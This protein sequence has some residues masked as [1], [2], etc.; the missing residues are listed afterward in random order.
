MAR[1]RRRLRWRA[2]GAAVAFLL[3]AVAGVAGN[4]LT[5]RLVP[6]LVAFVVL[7]A[8][9]MAITYLLE[10]HGG[11]QASGDDHG[12]GGTSGP[13]ARFDLRDAQGIQMG[14][15]NRQT[16]YFGAVPPEADHPE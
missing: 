14:D 6:A 5:G 8:A 15:H 13:D 11:R 1:A 3:A 4:Q 9:G 10:L 12:I 2:A 16:N 7:L